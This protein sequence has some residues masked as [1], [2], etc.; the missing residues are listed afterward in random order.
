MKCSNKHTKKNI[1]RWSCWSCSCLLMQHL[2]RFNQRSEHC[3]RGNGRGG[4]L[5]PSNKSSGRGFIGGL[6]G[7][8]NGKW[9][10]IHVTPLYCSLFFHEPFGVITIFTAESLGPYKYPLVK[11]HGNNKSTIGLF[12]DVFSYWK[13][14]MF[15]ASHKYL[16][17]LL[18]PFLPSCFSRLARA[19]Q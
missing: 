14:R 13:K 8:P 11:Y 3:F 15:F 19:R 7:L 1:N 12:V 17:S 5:A 18:L 2:L 9:L 6:N 16:F 4:R 10:A